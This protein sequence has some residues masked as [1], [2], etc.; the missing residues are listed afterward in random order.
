MEQLCTKKVTFVFT[1]FT[2]V[3]MVIIQTLVLTNGPNSIA[4]PSIRPLPDNFWEPVV[5]Q[6]KNPLPSPKPK[7][8]SQSESSEI[9]LDNNNDDSFDEKNTNVKN[10]EKEK[11]TN[12]KVEEK[13]TNVD[14]KNKKVMV[15]EKNTKTNVEETRHS[16]EILR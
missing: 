14:E 9:F 6:P 15:E 3:F 13:N 16:R 12:I 2:T 11:N 8:K 4:V 10:V 5:L 1:V 7:P